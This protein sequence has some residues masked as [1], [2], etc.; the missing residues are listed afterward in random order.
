MFGGRSGVIG[1]I[2]QG[3]K[4]A[5]LV[6]GGQA[7]TN[8]LARLVPVP[9]SASANTQAAIGL[10]SRVVA[11]V[12]VGYAARRFLGADAA[13]FVI[14]GG[15]AVPLKAAIMVAQIPVL[16]GAL[17]SDEEI[18]AYYE[19]LGSYVE[20]VP[21]INTNGVDAHR[22]GMGDGSM[23]DQQYLMAG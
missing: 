18:G 1:T 22:G 5:A 20:A 17:S 3:G 16:S 2:M 11:A 6:L 4:D 19:R 15:I 21:R 13:R 14:A 10:G 23:M 7:G 12:V 8:Y 9:A